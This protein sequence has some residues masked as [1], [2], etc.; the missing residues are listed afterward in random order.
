MPVSVSSSVTVPSALKVNVPVSV[1]VDPAYWTPAQIPGSGVV[2]VR[3]QTSMMAQV[4]TTP[5]PQALARPQPETLPPVPPPPPTAPT[6]PVPV[7]PM[8]S[9]QPDVATATNAIEDKR[10]PLMT[11]T[12]VSLNERPRPNDGQFSWGWTGSRGS[13]LVLVRDW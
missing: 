7:E 4:P 8:P 1:N 10:M 6:P 5:P 13:W 9:P 11:H 2:T 3:L 12:P